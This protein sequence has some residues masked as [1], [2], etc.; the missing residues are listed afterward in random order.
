MSDDGNPQVRPM[1]NILNE[2]REGRLAIELKPEDFVYIDRDC[3]YFKD[4]IQNIQRI[5][6]GVSRQSTWG[7]GETN[8]QMVSGSTLVERFKE[9]ANG[10][11][12]GNSVFAIMEMHYKIAEDIQEVHRVVRERMMQADSSFASEFNRLNETLPQRPPAQLPAGP[13]LL[14]DGT[15]R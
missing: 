12:D 7:L 9:K 3:Q 4:A 1:A 14:P 5:M 10:A 15:G 11:K 13:Y 8:Q 2:A 6:D